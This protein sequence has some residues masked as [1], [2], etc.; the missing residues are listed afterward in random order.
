MKSLTD[1]LNFI[2]NMMLYNVEKVDNMDGLESMRDFIS[3]DYI[4]KTDEELAA[5]KSILSQINL[6]VN[7]FYIP[8]EYNIIDYY[9]DLRKCILTWLIYCDKNINDDNQ[10]Y[11]FPI[12]K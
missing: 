5:I 1:C 4:R 12:E 7:R 2:D 3:D 8:D 6:I 11:T 10:Q 9:Y